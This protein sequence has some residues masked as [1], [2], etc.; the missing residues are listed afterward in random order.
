VTRRD[1]PVGDYALLRDDAIVAIAERKSFDNLLSDIGAIR[2]LH[3]SMAE[4]ARQPRAAVVIEAQYGDVLD[5]ARTRDWPPA[6]VT[7][8][9]AELAALHPRLPFVFA[10]NRK[11]ANVWTECWFGAVAADLAAGEPLFVAD[12]VARYESA[13]PATAGGLDE[14][15]RRAALHRLT[16]PFRVAELRSIVPEA[17]AGRVARVLRALRSEGRLRM[18]GAGRGARWSRALDET[19]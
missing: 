6:H 1:L 5:P 12:V 8:V 2:A 16:S 3:Q 9:V 13:V 15:L 19:S 10:G 7:R 17:D 18:D 14:R 4:L 11:L